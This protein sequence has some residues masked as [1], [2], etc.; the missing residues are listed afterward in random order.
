MTAGRSTSRVRMVPT[1]RSGVKALHRALADGEVIAML[2]DQVPKKA[3][4]AGVV[5][6]FFGHDAM[7]MTLIG[8]LAARQQ[9]PVL[10]V[11]AQRQ[12]DGRYRAEF[13]EADPA[14]A[15]RDSTIAASALNR[16]L[17]R[18]IRSSPNQYQWAYRRYGALGPGYPNPYR[19]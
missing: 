5:A 9:S 10:L 11:W 1:D 6:P 8:R 14:I 18:C 15:D 12:P 4:A 13:F 19:R 7:T 2:P 16:A 3:G 17:E